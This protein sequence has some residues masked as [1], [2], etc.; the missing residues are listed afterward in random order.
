MISDMLPLP[1][2]NRP[3]ARRR[4]TLEACVTI[5]AAALGSSAVLVYFMVRTE[6]WKE[7]E[8][9]ALVQATFVS[10]V[11]ATAAILLTW[12]VVHQLSDGARKPQGL[13]MWL[14]LGIGYGLLL[15]PLTGA[16]L[17]LSVVFINLT[18]GIIELG[19]LP[20]EFMEA[21]FR[22]PLNSIIYGSLAIVNG[23]LAGVLFSSGAWLIDRL[24]ASSDPV[25]S[26]R[27]PW[28]VVILLGGTIIALAA[29]GPPETLARLG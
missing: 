28:A 18:L 11:G 27:G 29:F 2:T 6:A 1:V 24:N 4:I 25:I 16:L 10:L 5:Y 15:P 23:L 14:V 17:P 8:H 19:E 21:L 7:P 26:A 20:S 9:L 22:A 3:T 13:L 12:P